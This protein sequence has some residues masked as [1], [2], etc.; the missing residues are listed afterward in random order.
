MSTV[1]RVAASPITL[2]TRLV[3]TAKNAQTVCPYIQGCGGGVPLSPGS[4]P[5]SES[6]SESASKSTK[7]TPGTRPVSSVVLDTN[8]RPVDRL[9]IKNFENFYFLFDSFPYVIAPAFSTL[10]FSTHAFSTTPPKQVLIQN[11]F[12]LSVNLIA[13]FVNHLMNFFSQCL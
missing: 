1:H 13:F 10:E 11:Y 7:P 8:G 4:C 2:Q 5:E 9:L 6:D 12:V 3:P